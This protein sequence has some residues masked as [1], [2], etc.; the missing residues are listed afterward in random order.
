MSILTNNNAFNIITYYNYLMGARQIYYN[1]IIIVLGTG[2]DAFSQYD[3]RIKSTHND[4]TKCV[5][6]FSYKAVCSRQFLTEYYH[7][8]VRTAYRML[9]QS[10]QKVVTDE[11]SNKKLMFLENR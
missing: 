11:M 2:I 9:T 8:Y 10:F 1:D 3:T 5:D 6:I 7:N 4:Q